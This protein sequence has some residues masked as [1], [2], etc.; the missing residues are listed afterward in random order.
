[1]PNTI[2][3]ADEVTL[4]ALRVLHQK[5][6]FIGS[7]NRGYDDSFAKSGAKI[8]ESLRVKLPNE[9][10]IRSGANLSAQDVTQRSVTLSVTN[11]KGVDMNFS[12]REL[13]MSLD[14]F[15]EQYIAPAMSVLAAN[16]EADAMNMYK[17]IYQQVNNVGAAATFNNILNARKKLIDSLA[18]Q[19]DITCVL[20]TQAN[21]D[22]VDSLKGLFQDS[23]NVS[24]QN[25]EGYMG[26]TG[27][28]DF[29]E[30]T[31]LPR[32]T[33]GTDANGYVVNGAGQT[34]AAIT[35]G[36]GTGTFKAG[37]I[38]T[39]A[40]CFR[41]HPETKATTAVLQ[42]FVVTADYAGGAGSLAI[43]PAI[44][45]SGATQNVA[46]SPTNGGAVTKVGGN[47]AAYNIAM[48]F[49]K[50]AFTFATADLQM[51]EGVHFAARKVIDGISMR[52]VRQ[53]DINTDK[54]PCR[55]DVFY[56]Y[57]TIRPQLA[58]RIATN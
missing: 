50:D 57:K 53:Y 39:F 55:I 38:V 51:P 48:A 41:V 32:H 36:T 12:T 28:M 27:G 44:V 10:T 33:S 21:V 29:A 34:G 16:I 31:L 1:M 14:Q 26:R 13:T 47:A 25:R 17:D 45:T 18:P 2:L 24:K 46:A 7:V 19:G 42:Q 9:F 6:N 56:G 49:H 8:G 30:N 23:T 58:T 37:D 40:G 20:D 5:C 3:T 4:E 54:I 35:V 22:L 11:Q 15:S 52:I 43:S